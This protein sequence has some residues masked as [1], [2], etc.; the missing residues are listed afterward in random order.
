MSKIV[1][2]I[3][4]PISLRNLEVKYVREDTRDGEMVLVGY[5]ILAD[6]NF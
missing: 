5:A 2:V 3:A 6:M 1:H 4:I